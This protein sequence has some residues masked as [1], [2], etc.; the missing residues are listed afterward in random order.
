MLL[1]F[2][3]PFRFLI[4]SNSGGGK[5][6][7]VSELIKNRN[8]CMIDPPKRILYF[9]KF[10]TSVPQSIQNQVEFRSGLPTEHDL[11]ND[12]NDGLLI[13]LD[14]LQHIIFESPIIALLFQQ[15]RHRNISICLLT[16]NLFP[17]G[18]VNRDI[19]LN[20]TGIFLL[21][22]VRDI[23]SIRTLS[24][25]LNPLNPTKLSEIYINFI[26]KPFKYI[27]INL[28]VD[29]PD[30]FRYTSDLFSDDNTC[31]VFLDESQ[32]TQLKRYEGYGQTGFDKTIPAFEY[33]F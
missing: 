32:I 9:A 17:K 22:T 27:F 6:T 16:Q 3:C 15:S 7:L 30:I 8:K 28:C 20:C 29:S 4:Y 19:S 14:D 21:K 10:I 5:S 12:S 33:Y 26:N 24:Y 13:V 2:K 1:K 31:E 25:Q 11:E 18:K 23:S